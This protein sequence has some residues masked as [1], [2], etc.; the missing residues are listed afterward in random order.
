MK[1][2]QW[3]QN[4]PFL[5]QGSLQVGT[6]F[7]SVT[8][9]K[10]TPHRLN[11]APSLAREDRLNTNRVVTDPVLKYWQRTAECPLQGEMV[12]SQGLSSCNFQH[13]FFASALNLFLFYS[14]RDGTQGLESSTPPWTYNH[15]PT[16]LPVIDSI[17][18]IR[19]SLDSP[20]A[21]FLVQASL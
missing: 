1:A 20:R 12:S 21:H 11:T 4:T 8:G 15:G 10:H 16:T 2:C 19:V 7:V 9:F 5:C 14:P 17:L 13:Q 18:K 6:Y 3:R